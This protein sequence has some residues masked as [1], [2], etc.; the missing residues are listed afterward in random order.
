[1]E[2][3]DSPPDDF[4]LDFRE[5]L[6]NP[7]YPGGGIYPNYLGEE[8]D[9]RA[10]AVWVDGTNGFVQLWIRGEGRDLEPIARREHIK[11]IVFAKIQA[12]KEAGHRRNDPTPPL[13]TNTDLIPPMTGVV[14]LVDAGLGGLKDALG[15]RL[16]VGAHAGDLLSRAHNHGP[17]GEKFVED[18]IAYLASVGIQFVRTWTVLPGWWWASKTGEFH[19]NQVGYWNRIVWYARL[20]RRHGLRWQLSM[21]DMARFYPGAHDRHNYMNRL[22]KTLAAEGGLELV[23]SVDGGNEA[24]QNGESDADKLA[25]AVRAFVEVLPVKLVALT[26]PTGEDRLNDYSR[27][28]LTTV[29]AYHGSRFHYR[30]ALERAWTAGY[31]KMANEMERKAHHFLM[32]EEG[33]GVNN[34]DGDNA[35]G[36]HIS[37]MTDSSEWRDLEAMGGLAMVHFA[38]RQ[39]YTVMTSPGVISDEPFSD[40]PAFAHA[41]KLASMLPQDIQSWDHFHGGEGR[42]W[43]QV[44]NVDRDNHCRCEHA[45]NKET[46]EVVVVI[47]SEA[48][49]SFELPIVADFTGHILNPGTFEVHPLELKRG[50]TIRVSFNRCRVLIGKR[51]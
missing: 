17:D 1:M 47:Y 27:P 14:E 39:L 29:I 22:A 33:V 41:V 37:V 9:A 36:S 4:T 10:A 2:Q 21:G 25:D 51:S 20:L 6:S 7:D 8:F 12:I 30:R 40:Y 11:H 50:R 44:V 49:G 43:P 34:A 31:A 15:T 3:I 46:G 24:W 5:W 13:P 23:L 35:R 16:F 26:S 42:G 28:P 38:T 45:L 18:T 48:P 32:N 19:P